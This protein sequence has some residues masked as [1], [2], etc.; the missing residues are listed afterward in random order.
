MRL[1]VRDLGIAGLPPELD[2]LRIAHLS[3]FHLGVPS[4][5][6]RAVERAV[7]WVVERRPDLVCVTGDLL[8]RP[9]GE[10]RLLALLA[11]LPHPYVVLGN[12]DYAISRDP[13][14]RP[15]ELGRLEHGTMLVDSAVEVELRGRRIELAGV[16][17]RTWLA[18]RRSNFAASD[19]DLRILL[20]HFPRALDTV[21]RGRWNLILAGH[22]H[23]GQIVLPYGF[24]KLLLAHPRAKYPEG[25][26]ERAGT[27]MHVSPGLGTTFVPL[28]LFA[29][30]EVTEL[31]LRS[32]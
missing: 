11:R 24:G 30:P 28:R 25:V 3:D 23:A 13:F 17:P 14:A 8:S 22:L 26:V 21:E 29:R 2:G 15:V 12:H 9:R 18:R 31:V 4:R 16:D 1:R 20:C 7:E 10:R 27:T 19:A 6:V 5:G 32:R